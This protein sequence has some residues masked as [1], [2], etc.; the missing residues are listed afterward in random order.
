MSKALYRVDFADGGALTAPLAPG[1]PLDDA[2]TRFGDAVRCVRLPE[3]APEVIRWRAEYG[4]FLSH[5]TVR[6]Y[7]ADGQYRG[8][9]TYRPDWSTCYP[10][11]TYNAHGTAG[12][13][14]PTLADA[15]DHFAKWHRAVPEAAEI[16]A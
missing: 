15:T 16:P 12:V 7:T 4:K 13:H 6:F 8:R 11:V 1:A 14:T 10:W 5:H 3:S 2:M 9:A